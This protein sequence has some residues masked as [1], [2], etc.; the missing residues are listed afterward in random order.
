M[1]HLLRQKHTSLSSTFAFVLRARDP[2][3]LIIDL[4]VA[5]LTEVVASD[6][7]GEE[8]CGENL[9]GGRNLATW[10]ELSKNNPVRGPA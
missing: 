4:T 5:R 3:Q 2:R 1:I 6:S 9:N 8:W 7:V 10:L